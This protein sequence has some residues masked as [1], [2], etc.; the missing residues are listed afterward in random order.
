MNTVK[1]FAEVLLKQQVHFG[2]IC[3]TNNFGVQ[4]GSDT[5]KVVVS[6]I[7]VRAFKFISCNGDKAIRT[8]LDALNMQEKKW[9]E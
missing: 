2:S 1:I 7:E 6:T 8:T 3:R 4:L 5:L 9:I